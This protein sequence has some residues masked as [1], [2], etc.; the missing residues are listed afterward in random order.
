MLSGDTGSLSSLASSSSST[1]VSPPRHTI[2]QL[3]LN[4]GFGRIK[5]STINSSNLSAAIATNTTS[6]INST[7][8]VPP[9]I[10]TSSHSQQKLASIQDLLTPTDNSTDMIEGVKQ[11]LITKIDP[12]EMTAKP[13]VVIVPHDAVKRSAMLLAGPKFRFNS[14]N[15][16]KNKSI[17]NNDSIYSVSVR[18]IETIFFNINQ[19]VFLNRLCVVLFL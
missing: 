10:I 16:S 18:T 5:P 1:S 13:I 19:F 9:L 6:L 3:A 17:V 12:V 15:I 8:T 14:K 2:N 7:I 11:R 4:M